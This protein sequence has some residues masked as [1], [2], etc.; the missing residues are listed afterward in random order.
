LKKGILLSKASYKNSDSNK[1]ILSPFSFI[2]FYVIVFSMTISLMAGTGFTGA[3]ST[4]DA[5]FDP[6]HPNGIYEID[7]DDAT[8][9]GLSFYDNMVILLSFQSGYEIF[10]W[11][12]GIFYL[13]MLISIVFMIF[14][15]G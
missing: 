6:A 9:C 12:L 7:C 3:G 14:G 5:V 13:L 11:L 8:G 15:G 2:V 4:S 1:G 10:N